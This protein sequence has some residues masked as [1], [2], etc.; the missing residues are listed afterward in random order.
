[1]TSICRL[2]EDRFHELDNLPEPS[3]LTLE[4]SL[5]RLALRHPGLFDRAAKAVVATDA[6]G[7]SELAAILQ[8]IPARAGL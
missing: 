3:S 6:P 7:A 4:E 2:Y 5:V 1:L 8:G